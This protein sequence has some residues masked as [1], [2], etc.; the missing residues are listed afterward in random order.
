MKEYLN[1]IFLTFIYLQSLLHCPKIVDLV[2]SY[3]MYGTPQ[4]NKVFKF[5]VS[6]VHIEISQLIQVDQNVNKLRQQI[7]NNMAITIKL[8]KLNF[9]CLWNFL[10]VLLMKIKKYLQIH[11]IWHRHIHMMQGNGQ[12]FLFVNPVM[13]VMQELLWTELWF[14]YINF[15][16]LASG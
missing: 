13:Q 1:I 8:K 2:K 16:K 15:F 3:S 10:M 9:I 12:W 4:Q 7:S 11:K 6:T 14:L 5:F